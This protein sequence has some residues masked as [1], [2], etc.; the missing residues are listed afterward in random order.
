M[1]TGLFLIISNDINFVNAFRSV[2][3]DLTRNDKTQI[4]LLTILA[5]DYAS[6]SSDIV[7]VIE[8]SL[9]TV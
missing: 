1:N 2:L 9:N 3:T 4:N 8:D 6:F 7:K 5:E